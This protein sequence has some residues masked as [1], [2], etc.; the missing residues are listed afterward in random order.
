MAGDKDD[1][2][3]ADSSKDQP[4]RGP[5]E[6]PETGPVTGPAGGQKPEA[7]RELGGFSRAPISPEIRSVAPDPQARSTPPPPGVRSGPTV[8]GGHQP[9][10]HSPAETFEPKEALP[11]PDSEFQPPPFNSDPDQKP[12][13]AEDRLPDPEKSSQ[14]RPKERRSV[15]TANPKWGW[16]LVLGPLLV[17]LAIIAWF[18]FRVL[19]PVSEQNDPL[20][21]VDFPVG[22]VVSQPQAPALQPATTPT[23]ASGPGPDD[24]ASADSVD[25]PTPPDDGE[26]N[27]QDPDPEPDPEDQ[28]AAEPPPIT[29][30]PSEFRHFSVQQFINLF[31]DINDLPN[32]SESRLV[33]VTDNAAA[34]TELQTIATRAGYVPQPT[35]TDESQLIGTHRLQP[36]LAEH[37][38]QLEQAATAAGHSLVVTT[39]Y[40][41]GADQA[42]IFR[43][44]LHDDLSQPALAEAA[45]AVVV[46]GYSRHQTGFAIDIVDG[47]RPSTA[48]SQT[49]AYDWL[50][51]DNFTVAKHFG[52]I[53]SH[54]GLSPHGQT[55][56]RT[57]FELVY[58]GRD[59]LLTSN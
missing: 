1:N 6:T 47:N 22:E 28:A 41:S 4:S 14:T 57:A 40:L 46:P 34:D 51:A 16:V 7:E 3:T 13:P 25:E 30:D 9:A 18:H 49:G 23:P 21:V 12:T 31:D 45:V 2:L 42:N 33:A 38:T 27:N 17:A 54:S 8:D 29:V 39:G 35:V 10:D 32:L 15:R 55:E 37:W 43:L 59:R 44:Q 11:D 36:L 26:T 5:K 58:V 20:Q 50:A 19:P 56:H 24:T 48:F 52:F 53:P